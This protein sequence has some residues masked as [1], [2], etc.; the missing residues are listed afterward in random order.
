MFFMSWIKVFLLGRGDSLEGFP[1]GLPSVDALNENQKQFL[2]EHYKRCEASWRSLTTIIW[3]AP[4][5]AAAINF[6]VYSLVNLF[7]HQF[8]N[9]IRAIFL[10]LL[11]VLNVVLTMGVWKFTDIQDQ[12]GRRLLAIERWCGIPVVRF[13]TE[14]LFR[15]RH[16]Y[17]LV[18]VGISVV[19]LALFLIEW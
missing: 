10:G 11:F 2:L 3:S 12:F 14:G 18:M 4:P 19:S 17:L 5:I 13:K 16:F 9:E 7:R 8:D 15:A 6:S 1:G